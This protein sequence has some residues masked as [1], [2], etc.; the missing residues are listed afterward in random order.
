[1]KTKLC[2]DSCFCCTQF[3]FQRTIDTYIYQVIYFQVSANA[4]FI[5]IWII[6][7]INSFQFL[8]RYK[9]GIN[10]QQY[11]LF[12][13]VRNPLKTPNRFLFKLF[14]SMLSPPFCPPSHF[15]FSPQF[16]KKWSFCIT[17]LK[18]QYIC[19]KK[20]KLTQQ[21]DFAFWLYQSTWNEEPLTLYQYS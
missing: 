1:M 5:S 9:P 14:I 3:T 19:R 16:I 6:I 4:L 17:F 15:P 10:L 11:V 7:V 12:C 21:R 8:L 13:G 18:K 20:T 2:K